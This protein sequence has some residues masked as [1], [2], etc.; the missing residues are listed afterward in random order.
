MPKHDVKTDLLW[1]VLG[2]L[3]TLAI[4][5]WFDLYEL[6]HQWA[7]LHEGWELDELPLAFSFAALGLLVFSWR[8]QASYHSEM[9]RRKAAQ[10]EA[11]HSNRIK[12]LFLASMSHEIRTPM[13]GVVGIV[14]LLEH[15]P[16]NEDQRELLQTME[17]SSRSL[18]RI[19][20][21]LLDYSK[22][23][24]GALD[25]DRYPFSPREEVARC[26][27]LFGV[28]AADQ[29]IL[30]YQQIGRDVPWS[31]IGD[32]ERFGQ[33]LANLVGNALKFTQ[34]GEVELR[35]GWSPKGL[36]VS[37]R[38][39]GHGME[40]QELARIFET[41]AQTANHRKGTG[42]GL[43]ICKGLVEQMG[44][45]IG[46]ESAPGKGS[47]FWFQLP[48]QSI[49][50]HLELSQPQVRRILMVEPHDGIAKASA[51]LLEPLGVVF[52]RVLGEDEAQAA[53]ETA[54]F[55]LV[56]LDAWFSL[57]R[58]LK[59][60]GELK[61]SHPGLP[62]VLLRGHRQM[63]APADG[64]LF[65]IQ[66]FHPITLSVWQRIAQRPQQSAAD[67]SLSGD[68][69]VLVVDDD[70]ISRMMFSRYL[71][72]ENL[73]VRLSSSGEEALG[74][75][76]QRKAHLVF[77]DLHMPGLPGSEVARQ[78][79]RDFSP[80]LIIGVSSADA[81]EG[82]RLVQAGVFDDFLTKPMDHAELGRRLPTWLSQLELGPA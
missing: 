32:G 52:M 60:A 66:A 8:R 25:L 39:T 43:A 18:L 21:N 11:E 41:Y 35:L 23:D 81:T 67:I 48:L 44:G 80:S 54:P 50:G 79:R 63:L 29:N 4:G 5:A 3:G 69:E 58:A 10:E 74:A 28:V 77:V 57:P 16:L 37:V 72:R 47:R 56:I 65:T 59:L 55:D 22:L 24:A 30:L 49:P 31:V 20:N 17:H 15:S 70:Q 45:V 9:L 6:W 33:I 1:L 12:S 51:A 2:V 34:S 78:I 46:V 13:T 76:A 26:L 71:D 61:A 27:E 64:A 68:I 82:H 62:L 7:S 53:L 40:P 14:D 19:I 75:L 73:Q 38:D 42:L 36:E